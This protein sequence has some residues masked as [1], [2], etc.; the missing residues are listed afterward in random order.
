MTKITMNKKLMIQP[1][2]YVSG[3][4]IGQLFLCC[5]HHAVFLGSMQECQTP[6][7]SKVSMFPDTLIAL[8]NGNTP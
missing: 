2:D 1:F 7:K 4:L 8:P 6:R 5:P 3:Y